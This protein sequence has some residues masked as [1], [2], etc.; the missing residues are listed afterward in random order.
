M[1]IDKQVFKYKKKVNVSKLIFRYSK[2][3]WRYRKIMIFFLVY[4]K[5]IVQ[6]I[7]PRQPK[8]SKLL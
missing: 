1:K 5:G 3:D 2:I 6:K 4:T 8:L 7:F